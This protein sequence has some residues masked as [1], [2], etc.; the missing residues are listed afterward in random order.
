[1]GGSTAVRCG[2]TG[3]VSN[4][5]AIYESCS[6]AP[7]FW[8]DVD[9]TVGAQV[10]RRESE[11]IQEQFPATVPVPGASLLQAAGAVLQQQQQQPESM[12]ATEAAVGAANV[13]RDSSSANILLQ[14]RSKAWQHKQQQQ[15]QQ[16]VLHTPGGPQGCP[17]VGL[18]RIQAVL[19]GRSI[20]PAS[21]TAHLTAKQQQQQP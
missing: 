5:R 2:G 10:V 8:L 21:L 14:Q 13:G 11:G 1:M 16:A 15:Q 17:A 9:S 20:N 7:Y 18:T 19:G 6:K 4:V 12:A 3:K